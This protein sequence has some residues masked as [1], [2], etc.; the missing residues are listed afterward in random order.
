MEEEGWT[1]VKPRNMKSI[2]PKKQTPVESVVAILKKYQPG[3]SD[4]YEH[5]LYYSP[6]QPKGELNVD[7]LLQHIAKEILSTVNNEV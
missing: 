4:G 1:V 7:S 2:K 5:Y 6:E 3:L